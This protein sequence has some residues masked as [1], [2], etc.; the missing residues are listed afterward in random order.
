M[1]VFVAGAT[2]AIGRRLVPRLRDAGHEVV[3]MTHSPSKQDLIYK[4]GAE[5]V[6]ADALLA[7]SVAQAVAENQP[8]VIV[9]ELT[10]L[11]GRLTLRRFDRDF[12]LTNRLR[13]EGTDHL[14]SAAR[15][16]GA[17]RFI[18][19]SYAGWPVARNGNGSLTTERDP[20]DPDP[21][22]SMRRSHAA[23]RHLEEAVVGATWITGIVLRYGGLY[24]P[25]TSLDRD[26]EHTELIRKRKFPIVGDG[27]GM[28]SLIHVDDA[29]T[30]TVAA[31][32]RGEA[33]IYNV[34]DD[35]PA[36]ASEL[37]PGLAATLGAKAP[38]HIPR[39]LARAVA[40]EAVVLTMTEVPGVSNAKAKERLGWHPEYPS[41]REG[42]STELR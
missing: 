9:H 23:I 24:G 22:P 32:E 17:K 20:L 26:G 31:V 37:L 33:G 18:A 38:I 40:G 39:V 8:D 10:A 21:R 34:V 19:Q 30:A 14:L 35:H 4:L 29:A 7:E 6:V 11:S 28:F 41:W 5:P 2:G 12:A 13:T 42:F 1:K 36:P 25:G 27:G 15:A 3:A 16:V